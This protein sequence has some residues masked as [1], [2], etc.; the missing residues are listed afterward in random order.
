MTFLK[1]IRLLCVVG[2]VLLYA[3]SAFAQGVTTASITGTVKDEQ[4]AVVPGVTVT[5]L[6]QPSGTSYEAIT[7]ADGRYVIPGMR[8]GGPY[9]VTAT[10]SG[11]ATEVHNG[12]TL[13]LGVAED[14]NF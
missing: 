3:G 12:V 5:A 9:T 7:Q 11:F 14:L 13:Q 10:L 2:A 8:V 4:G 6:H 1:R